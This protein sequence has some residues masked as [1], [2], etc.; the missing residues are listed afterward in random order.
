[1]QGRGICEGG[2]CYCAAGWTGVA[3]QL[4][5]TADARLRRERRLE[6]EVRAV[7][8]S[9]RAGVDA[10]GASELVKPEE[11]ARAASSWRRV[12]RRGLK[13]RRTVE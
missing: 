11:T 12:E 7:A 3:C 8:G 4:A 2:V 9:G 10:G 5:L 6:A 1:M 13:L